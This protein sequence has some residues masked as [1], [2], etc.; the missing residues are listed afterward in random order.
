MVRLA[1]NSTGSL[2]PFIEK[3]CYSKLSCPIVA[4]TQTMSLALNYPQ[5]RRAQQIKKLYSD[6]GRAACVKNVILK[7][8]H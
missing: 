7:S 3:S 5:K 1:K 4:K 6:S 2:T 8:V